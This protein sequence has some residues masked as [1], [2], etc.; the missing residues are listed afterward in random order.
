MGARTMPKSLSTGLP[1][2]YRVLEV[3]LEVQEQRANLRDKLLLRQRRRVKLRR[4]RGRGGN[5]NEA[6]LW[7]SWTSA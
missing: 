3:A 5:C 4:G 1:L 6:Q 2:P 7:R